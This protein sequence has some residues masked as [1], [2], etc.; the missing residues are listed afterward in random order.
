LLFVAGP[1]D[2]AL[3][4]LWGGGATP[5]DVC[6]ITAHVG[7]SGTEPHPAM[8]MPVSM[9]GREDGVWRVLESIETL[10][11]AQTT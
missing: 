9:S 2:T 5:D 4:T 11:K 6:D 8:A 1:G 7:P 10:V 3:A